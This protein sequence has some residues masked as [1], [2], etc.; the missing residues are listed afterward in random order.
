MLMR[1]AKLHGCVACIL[2]IR[3]RFFE[4]RMLEQLIGY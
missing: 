1:G 4:R 3:N 2:Q